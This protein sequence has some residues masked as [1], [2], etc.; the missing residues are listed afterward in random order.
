MFTPS[1]PTLFFSRNDKLDPRLGDLVRSTKVAALSANKPGLV[2]SGYPDDEGIQINGGRLGARK[3]PDSIRN[4][5]YRMTPSPHRDPHLGL[6]D[7]GN[8]NVSEFSLSD[9]HKVAEE[10]ALSALRSSHHYVGLGGGHDY[11]YPDGAAFLNWCKDLG[12]KP[13]VINFDAHLDVR[14]SEEKLSSGTPF[15]RLLSHFSNFDFVE[16]G[17]QPHCNS[18]THWQW[19][20]DRG[21]QIISQED[22]LLSG[23][24]FNVYVT[25]ALGEKLWQGRPTFISVDIDGFTSTAAM[26]CSQSWPTGFGV[27]DFMPLFHLLVSRLHVPLLGIYEVSPPLDFDGQTAKLA[28]Q[29]MHV[30]LRSIEGKHE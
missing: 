26:G 22:I 4:F 9:R 12:Q 28:A 23:E 2:I 29:I 20:L 25:R 5:F 11:G 15:Y 7:I 10:T 30:Y 8:L 17:V 14:P 16:I 21:G 27:N 18:K 24:S 6:Y 13:L 1:N 3:G 19:V